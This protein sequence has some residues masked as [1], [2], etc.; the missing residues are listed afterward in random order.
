MLFRIQQRAS[1]S[2]LAERALLRTGDYYFDRGDH[3]FAEDVYTAFL[4]RYPRSPNV[5][6]VQL[7]QAFSNLFQYE[8]PRYSPTPLLDAQQQ[9]ANFRRQFPQVA[10]EQNL[11]EIFDFIDE[12]L[13]R[14]Q[15]IKADFYR[16]TRRPEAAAAL[17]Q[18][19]VERYPE[20]KTAAE[21]RRLLGV[22]EAKPEAEAS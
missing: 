1:G 19:I 13:A 11:A 3:D 7:R 12:E 6:R 8:G 14:K 16:R 4:E 17:R 2:E 22:P 10:E 21:S 9:F 15:A 20:T 18:E 5:A